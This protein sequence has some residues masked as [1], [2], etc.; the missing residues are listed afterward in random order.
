LTFE[1][2]EGD[3]LICVDQSGAEYALPIDDTLRAVVNQA[4]KTEAADTVIQIPEVLRPKDIQ[5]LVRAGAN[6][7]E[8]AEASGLDLEHVNRY[9]APV[10]D[11]RQY[12]AGQARL[13]S[14]RH[15]LEGRTLTQLASQRAAQQGIETSA[16][17]WDAVR[18]A[19]GWVLR[20]EFES[21][22]GP[23]RAR[24][25]AD[26]AARTLAPLNDQAH[27]L[28]RGEEPDQPIPL[29]RH[30][31]AVPGLVDSGDQVSD[32]ED[33]LDSTGAPLSLL[34]GLMGHRGLRQPVPSSADTRPL[35]SQADVLELRHGGQTPGDWLD[36]SV[37]R[38]EIAPDSAELAAS[39]DWSVPVGLDET[40]SDRT[41]GIGEA[42]A[43]G[44]S[45]GPWSPAVPTPGAWNSPDS[46]GALFDQAPVESRPYAQPFLSE[47]DGFDP[48]DGGSGTPADQGEAE[49]ERPPTRSSRSHAKRSSV[50]CWDEIVFGSSRTDQ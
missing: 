19:E 31:S 1:R 21:E 39:E 10:L 37:E 14:P 42:G 20:L 28:S 23:V 7:A 3:R 17:I 18:Q 40:D 25:Q 32:D 15:D 45:G 38:Q 27:W 46:Q 33:G 36:E 8:L 22:A 24:W 2:A 11:E 49:P 16:L 30:L 29:L 47:E 13:F 35:T 6:P 44:P 9:A 5:T 4:P 43:N 48:A 50:P 34:D 26:L 41:L 12:V